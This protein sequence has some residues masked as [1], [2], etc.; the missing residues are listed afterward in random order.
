M[1]TAW[2]VIAAGEDRQHGGNAGYEDD[3]RSTY[4]WDD[5]VANHAGPAAGDQIALWDK[6]ALL[7]VSVIERIDK[8]EETKIRYRC[9]A[10]GKTQ[11]KARKSAPRFRCYVKTCLAEFDEP[12]RETLEVTTYRTDHAAAWVDLPGLLDASALRA[13]CVQPKSIQS[14]RELKWAAF[15]HALTVAGARSQVSLLSRGTER[16]LAGGHK[17]ALVRIRIGQSAFRKELLKKFGPVCALT[18]PN[19]TEVLEAAHL[20]RYAELGKHLDDGGI[21]LRRDLHRLFDLGLVRVNPETERIEVDDHLGP[22]QYYRALDGLSVAVK[23][24]ADHHKWLAAHWTQ[25][26]DRGVPN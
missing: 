9:A 5:T 6:T 15:E 18:G 23:L 19:P 13:L 8:R 1:T 4:H 7:G 14:I 2:L 22:F 20:Y 26:R 25:Y 17:T 3:P 11:F 16:V 21:L 24:S 12:E 10:C